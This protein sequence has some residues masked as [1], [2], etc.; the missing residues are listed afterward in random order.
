MSKKE[1]IKPRRWRES[2]KA[3]RATQVAFDV[4][5]AIIERIKHDACHRGIAP[6]DMIR[7]ILGLNVTVKPVRPRLTM[8]LKEE[9]YILLAEK[10]NLNPSEKLAI[11]AHMIEEI[12]KYATDSK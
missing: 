2:D 11:K 4:E 10:Y 1:Q 3:I 12:R 6:S 8:S 5:N 7:H 9:D